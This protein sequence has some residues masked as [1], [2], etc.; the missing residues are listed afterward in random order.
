MPAE[1]KAREKSQTSTKSTTST[2]DLIK[3]IAFTAIWVFVA[4]NLLTIKE[5]NLTRRDV[6]IVENNKTKCKHHFTT[7]NYSIHFYFGSI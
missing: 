6:V 7:S 3:Y 2:F 4:W 5:K 1:P